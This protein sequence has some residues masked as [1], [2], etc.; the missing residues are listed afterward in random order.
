ML[1]STHLWFLRLHLWGR[2]ID[3]VAPNT[4]T[5]TP[6]YPSHPPPT[7]PPTH[8]HTQKNR[9][10][11]FLGNKNWINSGKTKS[12]EFFY[13]ITYSSEWLYLLFSRN[14]YHWRLRFNLRSR[15][16]FSLK[17]TVNN[18]NCNGNKIKQTPHVGLC[19]FMFIDLVEIC[20]GGNIKI[21]QFEKI[22][23]LNR[24]HLQCDY[25]PWK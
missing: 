18:N 2:S 6:P 8:T 7:P 22:Y 9:I 19:L 17:K 14:E 11:T 4:L 15:L 21:G 12:H 10:C 1:P 3:A 25:R 16:L 13:H 20:L 5:P 23:S 24:E